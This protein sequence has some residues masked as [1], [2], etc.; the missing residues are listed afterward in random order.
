MLWWSNF[1]YTKMELVWGGTISS[2]YKMPKYQNCNIILA[3]YNYIIQN[4]TPNFG[5]TMKWPD[6]KVSKC[7]DISNPILLSPQ[8]LPSSWRIAEGF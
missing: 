1:A 5:P 8:A 6:A 2:G 4:L 3:Q 7:E